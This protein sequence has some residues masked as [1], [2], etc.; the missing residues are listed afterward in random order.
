MAESGPE[1]HGASEKAKADQET[2]APARGTEATGVV[3]LSEWRL[4]GMAD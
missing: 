2:K 4:R 3:R 1:V